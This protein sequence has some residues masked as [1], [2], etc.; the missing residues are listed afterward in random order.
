MSDKKIVE[1]PS[2]KWVL[3]PFGKIR[4]FKPADVRGNNNDSDLQPVFLVIERRTR[5]AVSKFKSKAIDKLARMVR[6]LGAN[7]LIGEEIQTGPRQFKA[8]GH[9]CLYC[10]KVRLPIKRSLLGDLLYLKP[11]V[12]RPPETLFPSVQDATESE[13]SNVFRKFIADKPS[14]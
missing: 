11:S 13:L 4:V 2:E 5:S 14:D 9:A 7:G 3:I 10:E 12:I 6:K 8:T 1:N